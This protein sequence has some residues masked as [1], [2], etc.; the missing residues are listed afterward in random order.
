[1][2]S[3]QELIQNISFTSSNRSFLKI[4]SKWKWSKFSIELHKSEINFRYNSE[5]LSFAF[6]PGKSEVVNQL[7]SFIPYEMKIE[8]LKNSEKLDEFLFD[9]E[10]NTAGI[11]FDDSLEVWFSCTI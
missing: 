10:T 3:H 5:N 4:A 7:M 8:K 6:S 11:A 2:K 1:M 9:Q